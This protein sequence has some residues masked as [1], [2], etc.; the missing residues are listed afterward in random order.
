MRILLALCLVGCAFRTTDD[1]HDPEDDHLTGECRPAADA[2][3][4]QTTPTRIESYQHCLNVQETGVDIASSEAEWNALFA[5]CGQDVPLP[6]DVDFATQRLAIAHVQCAPLE[7]HFSA[8]SP[9]EIVIG[10]M[11]EIRGACIGDLIVVPLPRS[12][13]PVRVAECVAECVACPPSG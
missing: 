5:S 2:I 3:P 11:A 13:K 9:D 12:S 4:L 7:F 1:D 10:V 8:E 6:A